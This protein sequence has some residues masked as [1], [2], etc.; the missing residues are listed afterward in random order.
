MLKVRAAQRR[1]FFVGCWANKVLT[2]VS[3]HLRK[4]R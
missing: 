2:R 1:A 3:R 4:P